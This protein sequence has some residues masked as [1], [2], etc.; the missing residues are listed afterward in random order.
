MTL[1]D[2]L[3]NLL[4]F[5][6]LDRPLCNCLETDS[7]YCDK[8]IKSETFY[9]I[10]IAEELQKSYDNLKDNEKLLLKSTKVLADYIDLQPDT[11]K[12]STL[13][14]TRIKFLFLLKNNLIDY[15][16]YDPYYFFKL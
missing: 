6:H 12:Y 15:T 10:W 14:N 2:F 4:L 3:N 11:N 16:A 8:C 5:R 1:K 9:T 7:K 13:K